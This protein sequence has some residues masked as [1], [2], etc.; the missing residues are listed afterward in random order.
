MVQGEWDCNVTST[1]ISKQMVEVNSWSG[2]LYD[3]HIAMQ[4]IWNE[5]ASTSVGCY[6][7]FKQRH[8]MTRTISYKTL[9]I[10]R[11]TIYH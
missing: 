11:R 1:D 6:I 4:N 8:N 7:T 9:C 5:I 2:L 10:F 3:N